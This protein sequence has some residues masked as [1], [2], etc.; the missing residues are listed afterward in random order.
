MTQHFYYPYSVKQYIFIN[1][2]LPKVIAATTSVAASSFLIPIIMAAA[3]TRSH[4]HHQPESSAPSRKQPRPR[5]VTDAERAAIE[6]FLEK[7][8]YSPR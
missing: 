8:H 5:P 7:V 4:F 3:T 6:P 2:P 1:K